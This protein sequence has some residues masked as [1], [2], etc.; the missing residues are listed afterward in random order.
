M[1]S[2]RLEKIPKYEFK[3]NGKEDFKN[4][5]DKYLYDNRIYKTKDL[6]AFYRNLCNKNKEFINEY[7]IKKVYEEVKK[8]LEE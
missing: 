6:E 1:Y 2:F 7:E 5:I 4:K 3:I 8:K